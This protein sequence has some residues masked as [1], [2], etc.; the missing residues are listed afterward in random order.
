MSQYYEADGVTLWNPSNGP[1]RLFLR[2]LPLFEAEVGLP[3][4]I[5]PM[6]SDAAI[7]SPASFGEFASA[8]LAWRAQTSHPVLQ[9]LSDGFISVCLVLAERA[10]VELN[11]PESDPKA[12]KEARDVEVASASSWDMPVRKQAKTLSRSMPA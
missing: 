8:L 7:V 11:W 4:G 5:G 12:V 2:Q 10:G 6:V 3:S 9:A 1:S